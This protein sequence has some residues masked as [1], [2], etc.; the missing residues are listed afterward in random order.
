[1]PYDGIYFVLGK[2]N[3]PCEDDNIQ[4]LDLA[5]YDVKFLSNG[6]LDIQGA[7]I[8]SEQNC[9]NQKGET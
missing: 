6:K 3:L 8:P 5:E 7:I 4:S 2:E 9:Y 1:M